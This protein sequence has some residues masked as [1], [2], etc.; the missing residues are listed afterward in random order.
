L[1]ILEL[2]R[3]SFEG[4]HYDLPFHSS[5]D[6]FEVIDEESNKSL[7]VD[8]EQILVFPLVFGYQEA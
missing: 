5:P 6:F 2:R 1:R 7:F 4:V 8:F 3:F